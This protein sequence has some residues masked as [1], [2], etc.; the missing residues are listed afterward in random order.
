VVVNEF[1]QI[2]NWLFGSPQGGIS[3][4]YIFL[5]LVVAASLFGLFFGYLVA[6]FR[7]GPSEAFYV[8]AKVVAG[9]GPDWIRSSP[10]RI[11][12]IARLAAKEAL[13]RR[14][15]LIAFA[16]FAVALL[17]GGW[18]ISGAENQERVYINFVMFGTQ[19]LI[20]MMVML[21]SAFSLPEDIRN[22]TIY[23]VT[24]KPVRTSEIVVGRILGFAAL[25]TG[26]LALMG[27]I[28]LLFV[29][30]GL[31]HSHA[32]Q[33]NENNQYEFR[34]VDRSQT[35][36]R[37]SENAILEARTTVDSGHYH[38]VE[39]LEDVRA[40]D[41][42][43][44]VNMDSVIREIPEGDKIVYERLQVTQVGGH[45]HKISVDVA[46]AG[47]G[48]AADILRE[49]GFSLSS[50]RGFF[51]ARVPLYADRLVFYDREGNEKSRGMSTGDPWS[52]RGYISGGV[53][54][55][56]AE[57]Y[58]SSLTEN[59]FDNP[60]KLP[61]E[62]TLGVYRSKTGDIYRRVRVGLQFESFDPDD[63]GVGNRFVSEQLEFESEEFAVQV[64]AIPRNLPGQIFSPAGELLESG[65][66]DLF[67]DFAAN[68][69]LKLTVRCVDQ[70][71]YL[72]MARAD[73]YFRA[74]D[75]P[76]W[77][78]FTKGYI[79]IW[80]QM[81]I[82]I[83]L[84]V[85]FSTFLSSPVVMLA[86]ICTIVFGFFSEWLQKF[87]SFDVEG[88]GPIESFVRLISQKNVNQPLPEGIG[89]DIMQSLDG[90][91]INM[92]GAVTRIV[93]N[94]SRL[95]FSDFLTYGYFVDNDR[96]LVAVFITAA[97]CLGLTFL[98]YFCLKTRELA[99]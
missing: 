92:V 90:V 83:C 21:I 39:L 41:A 15:I 82:V 3:A 33:P 70:D 71:Q 86:T 48:N 74:T 81:M 32:V 20:L 78:N 5:L 91:F 38:F 45:S 52:Y 76:Y 31:S 37:A 14:V 79:G 54:L 19:M 64:K 11:V 6:A 43:K 80:L 10:R 85:A 26:L 95:D 25:G 22:R 60:E 34:A 17:F 29:W 40:R 51:R 42:P 93:P 94:F 75:K 2:L 23:T 24:T 88:G 49:A 16:I 30:R 35:G 66:Y 18:F 72:G 67:D 97:F 36:H 65:T 89:T 87:A 9:A 12:A 44:P 73:I 56:R 57:Y 1:P 61:L 46:D 99:A 58:F 98:G 77:W 63:G 8:V 59:R 69:E 4:I 84:G 53:T 55:S 13:R 47:S 62:L 96:L 7:H 68:G 27:V 50:A 28:S